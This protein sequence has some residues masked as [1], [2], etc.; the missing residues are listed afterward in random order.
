MQ[1]EAAFDEIEF[2][3]CTLYNCIEL[4]KSSSKIYENNFYTIITTRNNF[5]VSIGTDFPWFSWFTAIVGFM[6][7]FLNIYVNSTA[8]RYF[9]REK[10]MQIPQTVSQICLPIYL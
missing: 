6:V 10:R 5:I 2:F 1:I 8:V 4:Q 7:G 3:P 9:Y